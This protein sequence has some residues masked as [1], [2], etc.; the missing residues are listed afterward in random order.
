MVLTCFEI[1]SWKLSWCHRTSQFRSKWPVGAYPHVNCQSVL[2]GKRRH[3][4]YW[5]KQSLPPW[6]LAF[7]L[8]IIY[9]WLHRL[10]CFLLWIT[11]LF[12]HDNSWQIEYASKARKVN[13]KLRQP[14]RA[15]YYDPA[16]IPCNGCYRA[17]SSNKDL[18]EDSDT[19]HVGQVVA[20]WTPLPIIQEERRFR[21][22]NC[23]CKQT[24]IH[25]YT[26]GR[27][28][29]LTNRKM[30]ERTGGQL[31]KLSKWVRVSKINIKSMPTTG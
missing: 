6:Q 14:T 15:I 27:K 10:T 7:T 1:L 4:Y 25:K 24:D 9:P 18:I 2:K 23:L 11:L 28:D 21:H 8:N 31:Q 16:Q 26:D 30:D 17:A 12:A 29:K 19:S 13:N 22:A 5:R 20:Y 3:G